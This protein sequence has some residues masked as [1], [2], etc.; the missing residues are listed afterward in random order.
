[1]NIRKISS[2]LLSL[3]IAGTMSMPAFAQN[4]YS[5]NTDETDIIG[6]L[7]EDSSLSDIS[8]NDISGISTLDG[9]SLLPIDTYDSSSSGA[10]TEDIEI[11]EININ[12][13]DDLRNFRDRVNALDKEAMYAT[14]NLN[15]DIDLGGEEWVPI[16]LIPYSSEE[17]YK[18]CFM[19]TFNGNNHTISNFKI[20]DSSL[21][22]AG[23]FGGVSNVRSKLE[24]YENDVAISNLNVS[25]ADINIVDSQT[26]NF[27]S[28]VC[29][30]TFDTNLVSNI[31]VTDS[32]INANKLNDEKNST[33]YSGMILGYGLTNADNLSA[34][35]NINVKSDCVALVGGILGGNTESKGDGIVNTI[36]N[37]TSSVN[38]NAEGGYQS[39]AGG[40]AGY[41]YYNSDISDCSYESENGIT[42]TSKYL[43]NTSVAYAAGICG[44]SYSNIYNCTVGS[45]P[46]KSVS[47]GELNDSSAAS[48]TGTSG[49]AGIVAYSKYNIKN[50]SSA[51]NITVEGN[52][53]TLMNYVGGI[54]GIFGND[55]PTNNPLIG[56]PGTIENCAYTGTS[57]TMNSYGHTFAGGVTARVASGYAMKNC[58]AEFDNITINSLSPAAA[59]KSSYV[60]GV[61]GSI[62]GSV[63]SDSISKGDININSNYTVYAGGISGNTSNSTYYV[64]TDE[65]LEAVITNGVLTGSYTDSNI[66]VSGR[67]IYAG[68]IS[69]YLTSSAQSN[70]TKLDVGQSRITYCRSTGDIN[71]TAGATS[72]VGGGIGYPFDSYV[73]D[74]YASGDLIINPTAAAVYGGGFAGRLKE[75]IITWE[76]AEN[77]LSETYNCYA[78]GKVITYPDSPNVKVGPFTE[79]VVSN[80]GQKPTVEV[81][82]KYANCYYVSEKPVENAAGECVTNLSDKSQYNL[83]YL[84]IWKI[85]NEGPKLFSELPAVCKANYTLENGTPVS[86]D[87]VTVAN[88]GDVEEVVILLYNALSGST[89]IQRYEISDVSV[90]EK[91]FKKIET[92]LALPVFTTAE[93]LTVPK[94]A[95]SVDNNTIS[96]GSF[97]ATVVNGLE[98]STSVKA[99]AASYDENGRLT[100]AAV[101]EKTL[102][103]KEVSKINLQLPDNASKLFIWNG[104]EAI[105]PVTTVK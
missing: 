92:N 69:G 77:P 32:N 105:A 99:V 59:K 65:G 101:T 1:M 84:N 54:T 22:S 61:T 31:H 80:L 4:N 14:V 95:V 49:A 5:V 63:V 9:I 104:S 12:S 25:N 71:V 51:A 19:G 57:I 10:D 81:S 50:C 97:G 37:C 89:S 83:D 62:Q 33:I 64:K 46:I 20:T 56:D 47:S 28:I 94:N 45:V 86:I 91:Y 43:L 26:L 78:S 40:I 16:G 67:S 70:T 87:S 42:S 30:I 96:D 73:S 44:Y 55:A 58:Y 102:A 7:A 39:M 75:S 17:K 82:P 21:C 35:G 66:N 13:T 2:G 85:T 74:C 60:G 98:S 93:L 29:G 79:S 100:T 90:S 8:E 88:P 15:T 18:Y 52:E 38:I 34:S 23:L 103:P 72:I 11:V 68:G 27:A 76:D 41:L 3:I 53:N 48:H 6:D 36:K 24:G